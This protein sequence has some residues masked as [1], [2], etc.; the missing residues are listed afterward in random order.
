MPAPL[1]YVVALAIMVIEGGLLMALGVEALALH[2]PIALTIVLGLDRK[3]VPAA[4]ILALLIPPIEWLVVGIPGVYG[5]GLVALFF[6]LRAIR[7][8][9]QQEWG[10]SRALVAGIGGAVHTVV[11]MVVLAAMGLAGEPVMSAVSWALVWT[12]VVVAVVTVVVGR[13]INRLDH[14]MDPR[15]SAARVS[16]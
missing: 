10:V 7:S 4:V 12:P 2:T 14:W 1:L 6:L 3:F 9:L 13:V 11:M 16:Y 15:D 5:L 8:N